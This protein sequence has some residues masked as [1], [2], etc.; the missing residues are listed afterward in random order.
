MKVFVPKGNI[1]IEDVTLPFEELGPMLTNLQ[2]D[3]FTGYVLV[4]TAD[5]CCYIFMSGGQTDKAMSVDA[6]SDDISVYR[7]DRML[8][9]LRGKELMVSTFVLSAR[10][11]EVLSGLFAF[12]QQYN[13]YEVRRRDM[14]KVLEGLEASES[15]GIIKVATKDGAYFLLV[16]GGQL[17]NDRFS[18][19]Y[20]EIVCGTDE[21][22]MHLDD[23]DKRGAM[24]SVYA[25]KEEEIQARRIQKN[26]ELE[27]IKEFMVKLE[28]GMFRSADLVKVE[29]YVVREWDLDPKSTFTVEIETQDGTQREYKC[30]AAKKMGNFAGITKKMMEEMNVAEN[31]T[32]FI[33]PI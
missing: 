15:T 24:I 2:T 7:V 5:A 31:D 17:L 14:N 13:E 10:M 16:S 18:R 20:G 30:Q 19:Q 23:I 9:R 11:V 22:K 27:K 25:E 3:A 6:A 26:N 28:G 29:D 33:R 1:L 12:Q 4:R 21:I 8:N 32:I